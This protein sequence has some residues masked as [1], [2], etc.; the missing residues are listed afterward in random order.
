MSGDQAARGG[1][2]PVTRRVLSGGRADD[3]VRYS[4]PRGVGLAAFGRAAFL[5]TAAQLLAVSGVGGM[6]TDR[7]VYAFIAATIT[8]ALLQQ[9]A[10]RM[11]H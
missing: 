4:G 3:G 7:P 8:G 2:F 5:K 9:G 6:L 1:G 10:L 11:G